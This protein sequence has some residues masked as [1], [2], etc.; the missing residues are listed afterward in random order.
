M[1]QQKTYFRPQWTC[2]RYNKEHEATIFYNLIEGMSYYFEDYSAQVMGYILSI[3]KDNYFTLQSL[4]EHTGI[5]EESIEPFMEQLLSL[6]MIT[7]SK[8]TPEMIAGYRENLVKSKAD[9]TETSTAMT[10]DMS[11]YITSAEKDYIA[12]VGGVVST[13]LELTYKCS[14]KCIH[15]YNVGATRNDDEVSYRGDREELNLEDYIRII[16]ELYE[17]GLTKVCLSGGDPFSNPYAW[18]IIEYLYIKGIAFDIYTNGVALKGK[19]ALLAKYYPHFV[20]ISVYSNI[21][22]IH[23]SITR[24]AGSF[25]RTINVV[26]NLSNLAVP[27]ALKCCIMRPNLHTYRGVKELADKYRAEIQYEVHLTDSLD[28]DKCVSRYLRLSPEQYE[29]VFRDPYVRAYVGSELPNYGGIKKGDDIRPCGAGE[30]SFCITPEGN[31]IPCCSFH[32]KIGNVKDNSI[33]TIIENNAVLEKWRNTIVGD[34]EECGKHDYCDF[35]VLC[36]GNNYSEHG[37]YLKA[38]E[39]NCY[40]AKLRYELYLKMQNDNYDPLHGMTLSERIQTLKREF[41]GNIKREKA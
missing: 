39:N 16:D 4:S 22:E 41:S 2:G 37:S 8:P 18:D 21:P 32:L 7:L 5:A 27:L 3:P 10:E 14:T 23:D 12:R 1:I 38:G 35:C 30:S 6:G 29:V 31:V 19:E 40:I 9:I 13:M 17:L 20:G 24:V 11:A 36:C 15:C 33:S 25:D 26:E 28:G 34:T